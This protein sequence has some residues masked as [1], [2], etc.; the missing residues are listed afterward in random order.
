MRGEQPHP[1][2]D[3][4]RGAGTIPACAGSSPHLVDANVQPRDHPRVRGEQP[5]ATWTSSWPWGPSPRARGA[6]QPLVLHDALDGTIPACAGS[7]PRPAS[8]WPRRGDH[9]RVRGEQNGPEPAGQRSGGPSPRAR[10]AAALLP[11]RAALGGTIP[12]CA[13]SSWWNGPQRC[14]RGDH[15]RVRG[16]QVGV[17]GG[18]LGI[19]G[20]SPRAR[21]AA[22]RCRPDQL[23]VGTIPAC[24]GSRCGAGSPGGRPRDHPRV[25]GEQWV[26]SSVAVPSVGPSPRARGA[27]CVSCGFMVGGCGF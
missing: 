27:G 15:P 25:R 1:R 21:G 20:P 2:L 7:S 26:G 17:G 16:E 3:P 11:G 23:V 12:A 8:R 9:P 19:R 13:G 24:A 14:R 5:A 10:G 6:E 4:G 22:D 18:D